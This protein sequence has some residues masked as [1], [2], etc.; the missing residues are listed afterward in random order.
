M[1]S[2]EELQNYFGLQG[3]QCGLGR[4]EME[5]LRRPYR[6]QQDCYWKAGGVE[7]G[8]GFEVPSCGMM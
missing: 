1:K 2:K 3:F 4:S 8:K 7:V 6:N 5:K